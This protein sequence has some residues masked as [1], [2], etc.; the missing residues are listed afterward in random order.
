MGRNPT[1]LGQ[2]TGIWV[3]GG[4]IVPW[5]VIPVATICGI[6]AF[7]LQKNF[8]PVVIGWIYLGSYVLYIENKR[9]WCYR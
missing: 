6:D 9:P 5:A 7:D 2:I 4:T 3:G 1:A 8:K